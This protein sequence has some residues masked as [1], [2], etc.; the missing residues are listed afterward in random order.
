MKI[1]TLDSSFK[2]WFTLCWELLPGEVLDGNNLSFQ[3]PWNNW[4]LDSQH[5]AQTFCPALTLTI[6]GLCRSVC[7]LFGHKMDIVGWVI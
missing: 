1:L 4:W 3:M 5:L 7:I 2:W 6:S